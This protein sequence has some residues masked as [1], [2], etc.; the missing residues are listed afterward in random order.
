MRTHR[1]PLAIDLTVIHRGKFGDREGYPYNQ[2]W[3]EKNGQVRRLWIKLSA[4]WL[5]F[6]VWKR[7]T[8]QTTNS[9]CGE[10]R[11]SQKWIQS[12]LWQGRMLIF[13]QSEGFLSNKIVDKWVNADSE[14]MII[15]HEA[16]CNGFQKSKK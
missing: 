16:P 11:I 14:N 13:L 5:R 4:I 7:R 8:T 2:K 1:K 15:S 3:K 6:F 10:M 12:I 9:I